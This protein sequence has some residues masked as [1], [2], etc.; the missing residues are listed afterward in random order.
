MRENPPHESCCTSGGLLAI[1]SIP[2][3]EEAAPQ[4]LPSFSH[5]MKCVFKLPLFIRTPGT[6][7]SDLALCPYFNLISS[8]TNFTFQTRSHS[9]VLRV[10]VPTYL[11]GVDTIQL[12]KTVIYVLCIQGGS[13]GDPSLFR[14]LGGPSTP[15]PIPAGHVV[16]PHFEFHSFRYVQGYAQSSRLRVLVSYMSYCLVNR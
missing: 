12:I 2:R 11:L 8:L 9:E 7:G 10:R 1:F 13:A 3:L 5:G 6:L 14:V 15:L 16:Q 4:S